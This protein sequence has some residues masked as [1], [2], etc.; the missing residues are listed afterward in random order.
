MIT[1]PPQ[2]DIDNAGKRLLRE[3][4]EQL[5]W[6]VNEVDKDYGIDFNVQVFDGVSPN[7]IWFHIQLKSHQTP[8]YSSD[9]TFISEPIEIE[10]VRHFAIE[11]RQ[12]MFLVVADVGVRQL[13]WHCLQLDAPLMQRLDGN[14]QQDTM[15]VRVPAKQYL[16]GT[17][18]HL[19]TALSLSSNVL[20]NR[21]LTRGSIADFAESLRY[22]GDPARIFAAIQDKGDV[23]RLQ[24]IADLFHQ[25]KLSEARQRTSALL[26]DPDAS[27]QT[28]FWASIQMYGIDFR[29]IV[30]SD[31]PQEQI[32]KSHLDH[33]N[34]LAKI[35]ADG[36]KP[37]KF[38]ALVDKRSAELESLAYEN[39]RLRLL[40]SAHSRRGGNPM[41]MLNIY[42]RRAWLA[43]AINKKYN[44][45]VRLAQYAAKSDDPWLLGRALTGVTNAL[46][47]YLGTLR[48]EGQQEVET[49]YARSA[50]QICKLSAWISAS[51]GD[52]NGIG[53]AVV[54]ALVTVSSEETETYRWAKQAA[55]SINDQEI[56]DSAI[57]S[58]N[59]AT[60]R[61]KGERVEGDIEGDAVWQAIQNMASERGVD[62]SDETSPLVKALRIGVRDDN[63][64]RVLCECEHLVISYGAIGPNARLINQ[65]FNMKTACSKVVNCKLHNY[66][67]E[68]RDLDSAYDAFKG[69]HCSGC[70]DR[71]PRPEGWTFDGVLTPSDAEY[72]VTLIGTPYDMRVAD[73]D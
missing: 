67:V 13:Y 12:P 29:E 6:I 59:H 4:L 64:D 73:D 22:S 41:L 49:P 5:G 37:F 54:A 53:M 9:R 28:K 71:K 34:S 61:W 26:A 35:T 36:P 32:A 63:F 38:Y 16:P 48:I 50:L 17:E 55:E 24:K 1:R 15:T 25:R 30:T 19:L 39:F 33:A 8:A 11:L 68:A 20:A 47:V 51:T 31:K 18:P 72:L 52:E 10:H 43:R 66:H 3:A 60:L 70:P 7:G 65:L 23:L 40:Q 69:A 27:V 58:V 42:A 62:I 46:S 56:R 21:Q 2:H 45:C 44:Q 14:L 57:E